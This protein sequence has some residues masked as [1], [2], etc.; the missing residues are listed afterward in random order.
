MGEG[1]SIEQLREFIAINQ[2][3]ITI[4]IRKLYYKTGTPS[5]YNY[6]MGSINNY[7]YTNNQYKKQILKLLVTNEG[8]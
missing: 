1:Q 8:K 3:C 5:S 4:C 7:R 6:Y 2:K